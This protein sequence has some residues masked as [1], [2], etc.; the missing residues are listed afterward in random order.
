MGREDKLTN[1]ICLR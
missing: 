1:V